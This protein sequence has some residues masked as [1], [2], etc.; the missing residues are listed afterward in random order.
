MRGMA[1]LAA[2]AAEAGASELR[3][4]G[5][6]LGAVRQKSSGVDLVTDADLASG[7][8]VAEAI[9]RRLPDA[10]FV[11]EEEEVYE[12]TGV[13]RGSLDDREVWVIDPLD[14]TTSFVHGYPFYS[15]S[16]A[17][18]GDGE[19]AAGAV[20]HVSAAETYVAW[21]G[22]GAWMGERRLRC[23]D[24]ASHDRALLVTGFPYD[25][26]EPFDRQVRL[27]EKL[28]RPA[29]DVRRDGSAALDL[30]LI[31]SGRADAYWELGLHPWDMA[32]GVLI[33]R[34]AGALV[35]AIDGSPWAPSTGDILAANP[36]LH[37]AILAAIAAADPVRQ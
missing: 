37:E 5:R 32:A 30:C 31:S 18:L 15:V 27:M 17:L 6:N 24:V 2:E 9:R 23:S 36:A 26:G 3:S 20:C 8:R 33:A 7:V 14:G 11:I 28:V 25:R 13:P 21:C 29:H 12:R 19:P 1:E 34:E 10:R 4:R 35:T 16:V 22:G